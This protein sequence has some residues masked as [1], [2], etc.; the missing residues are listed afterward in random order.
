MG[1]RVMGME[2]GGTVGEGI[3]ERERE[4]KRRRREDEQ[5]HCTQPQVERRALSMQV[6]GGL[7]CM[8]R[9]FSPTQPFLPLCP[10]L[11]TPLS[12][13]NI[14]YLPAHFFF[15]NF[16]TKITCQLFSKIIIIAKIEMGN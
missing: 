3:K 8:L 5:I 1:W 12:P 14:I 13:L 4:R 15:H 9:F 6:G 10:F 11:S 7:T 16:I 2:K